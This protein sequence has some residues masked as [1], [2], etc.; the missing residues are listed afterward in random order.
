VEKSKRQLVVNINELPIRTENLGSS[1]LQKIFGGCIAESYYCHPDC[2][3][4]CCPDLF[5]TYWV[6]DYYC[7]K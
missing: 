3:N 4:N 6:H 2:D 7:L 1:I 5:C